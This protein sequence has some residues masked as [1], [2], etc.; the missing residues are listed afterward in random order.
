MT[1]LTLRRL[2]LSRKTPRPA[3]PRLSADRDQRRRAAAPD[4]ID[5][6]PRANLAAP[7]LA[8]QWF[9]GGAS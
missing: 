6:M 4:M 8:P 5:R 1:P 3:G 9:D 2:A 7:A